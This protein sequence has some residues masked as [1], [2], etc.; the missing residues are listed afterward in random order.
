M[1]LKQLTRALLDKELMASLENSDRRKRLIYALELVECK[2]AAVFGGWKPHQGDWYR[3]KGS[4]EKTHET[5]DASCDCADHHYR[6]EAGIVCAHRE[7]VRAFVRASHLL[8]HVQ[9]LEKEGLQIAL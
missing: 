1:N 8:H 6:H 4:Q 5:F 7:L 3:V 9:A 2:D